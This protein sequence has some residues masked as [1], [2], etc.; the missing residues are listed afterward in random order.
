MSATFRKAART[1]PTAL[2]V[3]ALGAAGLVVTSATPAHAHSQQ[4]AIR[5][6]CGPNYSLLDGGLREVRI[7][8]GE[9]W[10]EVMLT[11]DATKDKFC[12]V[13]RKIAFH[14]EPTRVIAGIFHESE[15]VVFTDRAK[16]SHQASVKLPAAGECAK[17]YGYVFDPDGD[18]AFG[19]GANP[20][21]PY[22]CP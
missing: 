19:G 9:V 13:T 11:Y 15:G 4:G 7:Q 6:G 21:E 1:F 14:G 5:A 22:V 2:A 12:V 18:S 10:G 17:Y 20:T 8:A 3:S 16:V